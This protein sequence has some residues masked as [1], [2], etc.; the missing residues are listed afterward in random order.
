MRNPIAV[1]LSVLFAASLCAAN[2]RADAAGDVLAA[3]T[4]F[5]AQKSVRATIVTKDGQTFTV[6][7]VE[8]NKLRGTTPQGVA[9]V[10]I[11]T[12]SWI[13][14][15]G[16]WHAYPIATKLAQTEMQIARGSKFQKSI[17]TECTIT[18]A[19]MSTA[20]GTPAHKYHVVNK[21]TG[22]ALDVWVASG[23][24]VKLVD[25]DT[26]I[27]WSNFNGVADITAPM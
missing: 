27:V 12:N 10:A 1:L 26:T 19:G 24:P 15:G 25:G 18:D 16:G 2:A 20:G 13:N 23:L 5:G 11:G 3:A 14:M 4:N 21:S 9:F 8:P 6:D 22:D 7:M 17:L